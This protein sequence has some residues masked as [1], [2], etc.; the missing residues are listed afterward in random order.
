[1]WIS[2]YLILIVYFQISAALTIFHNRGQ[3]MDS[4]INEIYSA[5]GEYDDLLEQRT[6]V[7]EIIQSIWRSGTEED[8]AALIDLLLSGEIS[9]LDEE[10]IFNHSIFKTVMNIDGK[11][12]TAFLR[13]IS[14]KNAVRHFLLTLKEISKINFHPL[15]DS[16]AEQWI[17]RVIEVIADV[18]KAVKMAAADAVE[19]YAI[20]IFGLLYH[21]R[22]R[23]LEVL[24]SDLYG[25][26]DQKREL[27][28]CLILDMKL[29]GKI[30]YGIDLLAKCSNRCLA[31]ATEEHY[32]F[33]TQGFEANPGTASAD[34]DTL[35]SILGEVDERY[36]IDS[37]PYMAWDK[38]TFRKS[39]LAWILQTVYLASESVEDAVKLN[40]SLGKEVLKH[41]RTIPSHLA[42]F[43][44]DSVTE[45]LIEFAGSSLKNFKYEALD[46]LKER[47]LSKKSILSIEQLLKS[48][49][50]ILIEKCFVLLAQGDDIN[51]S[52]ER[53][54]TA[55]NK[56]IR[57]NCEKFIHYLEKTEITAGT[58]TAEEDTNTES[59]AQE[60]ITV[61][62][63]RLRSGLTDPTRDSDIAAVIED[64]LQRSVAPSRYSH[65]IPYIQNVTG[66][67][68][69]LKFLSKKDCGP[70]PVNYKGRE[71]HTIEYNIKSLIKAVRPADNES[72]V[73]LIDLQKSYKIPAKQL[74]TAGMLNTKLMKAIFQSLNFSEN[75]Y[76][77]FDYLLNRIYL[78]TMES[79]NVLFYETEK[80]FFNAEKLRTLYRSC[81]EKHVKL[82]I[83]LFKY[84]D[85][86]HTTVKE[87]FNAA[88]G[89]GDREKLRTLLEKRKKGALRTLALFPV[90]DEQDLLE[91]YSLMKQFRDQAAD[92]KPTVRKRETAE[93]EI[94]LS[95]LALNAGYGDKNGLRWHLEAVTLDSASESEQPA[96]LREFHRYWE[97]AMVQGREI[98]AAEIFN[99]STHTLF[100][101][102]IERIIFSMDTGFGY[103]RGTALHGPEF[104]RPISGETVLKV[105]HIADLHKAD[106][107]T[108]LKEYAEK[109]NISEPFKQLNRPCYS[110]EEFN[111]FET[112][113]TGEALE[114][115]PFKTSGFP[116]E[117]SIRVLKKRGWIEERYEQYSREFPLENRKCT[118][119]ISSTIESSLT[120]EG[121]LEWL[122]FYGLK[123]EEII[124]IADVDERL[125]SE[126]LIDLC[127][128]LR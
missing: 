6:R 123:Y 45:I 20:G 88:L 111:R 72:E 61:S 18:N 99:I 43:S 26:I 124:P 62:E 58:E 83:P 70:L 24:Q 47:K 48:K 15:S 14:S 92:Q 66:I 13:R 7:A 31:I 36:T 80:F 122:L 127:E 85:S 52:V 94:A 23:A 22:D 75:E 44:D 38:V 37:I 121:I 59:A 54:S 46:A 86:S 40:L 110:K 41:L 17:N 116:L 114:K 118:V 35:I 71:E 120:G 87:F 69:L 106:I 68:Y 30:S 2:L 107:V 93:F 64:E 34:I 101:E 113:T 97:E 29:L 109:L 60:L 74:L 89:F 96:L 104:S 9:Y 115:L 91:R 33:F 49:D 77:L 27:A 57:L 5:L 10:L 53:L 19:S 25:E 65:L 3:K 128:S 21:Q 95:E 1:M 12:L 82:F 67:E 102:S 8:L 105:A 32:S 42:R 90:T 84:V 81:S 78:L 73:T 103:I 63:E 51:S 11:R 125:F 119:E 16:E 108:Q 79:Y 112:V 76:E 126:A 4:H 28:L 56:Q 100:R 50:E 55:K 39:H 117:K 98:N